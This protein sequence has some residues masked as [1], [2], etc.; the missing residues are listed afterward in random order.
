[1]VK[2]LPCSVGDTRFDP[3]S[4][5]LPHAVEPLS[6]VPHDCSRAHDAQLLKAVCPEPV[7]RKKKSSCM[8]GV[9]G[10]PHSLQR[11]KRPG[12]SGDTAQQ[13]QSKKEN[14]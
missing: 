14:K 13:S 5:K 3:W 11:E 12:S 9:K 7:L 6:H 2:D 10:S 8:K 1:M 4:W